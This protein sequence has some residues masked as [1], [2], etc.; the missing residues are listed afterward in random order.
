MEISKIKDWIAL[1]T[2]EGIGPKRFINLLNHL[3]DP[4]EVLSASVKRLSEIPDIGKETAKNI[5][6]KVKWKTVEEQ[7]KLFEK[8][9]KQKDNQIKFITYKDSDYP[10][11]LKTI[12][13]P[14]PFLFVR[15]ELKDED[16]KALAI[17]GTRRASAYGKN[18]AEK[19][20]SELVGRGVTII[21][22]LARGIDSIGHFTALKGKG[23]TI[24]VFGS[25]LDVI[26]PQEHARL[27]QSITENGALISEFPLGTKPLAEN[28]PKRNRLISGLSLGVIVIEAPKRSGALLTAECALDQGRE[29]FAVPGNIGSKKSEGSNALI[30]KGAALVTSVDDIL[31]ELKG[32]LGFT[33]EKEKIKL[34]TTLSEEEKRVFSFL[35]LEPN[36]I[37]KIA[38]KSNF[39]IPQLLSVLLSLELKGLVKQLSGKMFVRTL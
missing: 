35:S 20:A 4:R 26:Y 31:S 8:Y 11:N 3:G 32:V 7:L 14:P 22:G 30:K 2:V 9:S 21:S 27:A 13:D 39:K 6:N 37:D 29:V 23:R 16:K 38:K 36:H 18:V 1:A 15:G 19:L 12:Y 28:F 17:V 33:S 5:K 10:E 25:G 24:A 34:E